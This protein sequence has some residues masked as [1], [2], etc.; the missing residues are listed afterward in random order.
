MK[1]YTTPGSPF[2]MHYNV[3]DIEVALDSVSQICDSGATVTF[4]RSGGYITRPSG[5]RTTFV[6]DG[7]TYL[8]EMWVKDPAHE[9]EPFSRQMTS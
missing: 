2:S 8:R 1:G 9:V 7:D 4:T 3:A 6:R 5:E